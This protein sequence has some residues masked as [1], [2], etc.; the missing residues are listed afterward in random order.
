VA[1]FA[2]EDQLGH[3]GPGIEV[4]DFVAESCVG[5]G[6]VHVVKVELVEL[7]VFEGDVDAFFDVLR[8]VAG[9]LSV[10]AIDSRDCE[11]YWSFQSLLVIQRSSL[12]SPVF[13]RPSAM[14]FPT[15]SWFL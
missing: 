4:L 12:F 9:R 5:D 13:A 10:V 2:F 11:S 14:P 1:G 7:E 3:G 6:P 8:A 15:R